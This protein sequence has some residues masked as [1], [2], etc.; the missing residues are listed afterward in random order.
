M[1]RVRLTLVSMAPNQS[2][3]DSLQEPLGRAVETLLLPVTEDVELFSFSSCGQPACF[4]LDFVI[5]TTDVRSL[6][7][8]NGTEVC[9]A[10]SLSHAQTS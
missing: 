10:F 3:L 9:G 1:L 4:Q 2:E 6:D 5:A 8:L 7:F